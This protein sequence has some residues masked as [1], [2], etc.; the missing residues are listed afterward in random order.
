M[1]KRAYY[2]WLL[3]TSAAGGFPSY[4]G[5][6]YGLASCRYLSSDGKQCA[7]APLITKYDKKHEGLGA[8]SLHAAGDLIVPVGMTINDVWHVMG[9]HLLRRD[10]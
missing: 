2:D 9:S 7:A 10:Y 3:A 6:D 8:H 5:S 4:E 1:T